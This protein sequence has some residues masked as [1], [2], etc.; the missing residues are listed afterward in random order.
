MSIIRR[1]LRDQ[2]ASSGAEF[3]LALPLLIFFLLGMIDVGRFMWDYNSAEKATQ[4][5]VR[6]AVATNLIPTGLDTYSFASQGGVPAG[7]PVPS[8]A[9]GGAG[10]FASATC[11]NT[12]CT[13]TG[14]GGFCGTISH[15]PTAF[16]A[17]VTRMRSIYGP[18]QATNVRLEYTNIGLGYA[19]DP[20]G[21]DVAP[22]VTLHL[23]GMTFRP[24]VF[25][26]FTG[27]VGMPAF[28]SALTLEDGAGTAAN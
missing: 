27:N 21:P 17:L 6:F 23:T 12:A 2:S 20:N 26:L 5:G 8:D 24:L 4:M 1:L 16:S 13:C 18:I 11:T 28:T 7:S 25:A 14:S 9:S 19:G 15:D 3:I 10:W 22:L